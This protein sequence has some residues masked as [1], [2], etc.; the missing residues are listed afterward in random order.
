MPPLIPNNEKSSEFEASMR[1]YYEDTMKQFISD[2]KI[3]QHPTEKRF[4]NERSN[5]ALDLSSPPL[6]HNN[7]NGEIQQDETRHRSPKPEHL[8]STEEQ[9]SQMF[10]FEDDQGIDMGN[11]P[12]EVDND[13]HNQPNFDMKKR[14]RT[15]MTN[16]QIKLMKHVFEFHKTPNM[17]E[18]LN[19]AQIIGLQ[20]RVVQV[21]FQNARAK[22][23]KARLNLQQITGKDP[24]MPEPPRECKFCIRQFQNKFGIQEHIFDSN[25]L[26][27]VRKAIES[28]N[29]E[30]ETPG[31]VLNQTAS[32]LYKSEDMDE[33]SRTDTIDRSPN[34]HATSISHKDSTKKEFGDNDR[35]YEKKESSQYASEQSHPKYRTDQQNFN[36][37]PG[38]EKFFQPSGYRAPDQSYP[39]DANDSYANYNSNYVYQ[40][41]HNGDFNQQRYPQNLPNSTSHGDGLYNSGYAGANPNYS[42]PPMAVYPNHY[43]PHQLYPTGNMIE[44]FLNLTVVSHLVLR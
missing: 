43:P 44:A 23:K 40:Q 17:N 3:G 9:D 11:F 34:N 5:E 2:V 31:Y 28:G 20:K 1:K 33:K 14:Y 7:A 21:W 42:M 27:N 4:K 13:Q 39:A 24:E 41:N 10:E 32:A 22:E 37:H 12:M 15:Q 30:P 16:I 8:S 6:K 19:L 25:H 26:D 36:F 38:H 18:C 35:G 29:Y